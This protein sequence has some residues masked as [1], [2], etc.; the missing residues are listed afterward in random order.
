MGFVVGEVDASLKGA[1]AQGVR[2]VAV[3]KADPRIDLASETGIGAIVP[4]AGKLWFITYPDVNNNGRGTG[5][6]VMDERMQPVL[7]AETNV[8]SAARI[9]FANALFIGVHKITD[10]GVVTPI[11]GFGANDR[12]AG[13]A[14]LAGKSDLY[15]MTMDG[16]IWKVNPTTC[17]ATQT[18]LTTPNG[19]AGLNITGQAHGKEVWG[20]SDGDHLFCTLNKENPD[21][22]LGIYTVSTGAWTDVDAGHNSWVAVA[23]SYDGKGHIFATGHDGLSALLWMFNGQTFDATP[24]KF[25]IPLPSD[26]QKE[27]WQQ[28]WMRIRAVETERYLMD[29]HGG[30]FQL[31]PFL[32]RDDAFATAMPRVEPIARHMRTI[33]DYAFWNGYLVLGGNQATPQSGNKYLN[34][35]QPQSGLLFTTLDDIWSWGKPAGT[36]FWYRNASVTSGVQSEYMLLR[37]YNQKELNLVNGTGTDLS[38]DVRLRMGEMAGDYTYTT[39]TVPAN[40]HA[41]VLLPAAD[42]AAVR[43]AATCTDLTAW[44]VCS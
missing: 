32:A 8:T 22:R 7:V 4:F 16:I 34:V 37:G 44:L 18:G 26:Q 27:G 30:F 25:R 38:V 29:L 1:G 28:E 2:Q 13:Y 33:P 6:W 20:H 12:I 42:W 19:Q 3:A 24:R 41:G 35:G 21:G 23:G 36:G 9:T 43:P 40:S 39:I 5:L 10:A 31:S 17:V 11:T 14:K 15:A